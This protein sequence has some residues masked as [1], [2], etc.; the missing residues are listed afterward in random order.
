[1][2]KPFLTQK[3]YSFKDIIVWDGIITRLEVVNDFIKEPD[4][5]RFAEPEEIDMYL[6]NQN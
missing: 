6:K 5:I 2:I 4:D 1:M 3:G